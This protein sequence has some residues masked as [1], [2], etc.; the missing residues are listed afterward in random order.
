MDSSFYFASF[1]FPIM[2]TYSKGDKIM[3]AVI[4]ILAGALIYAILNK[5]DKK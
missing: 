2:K 1:T 3:N 5:V 4:A